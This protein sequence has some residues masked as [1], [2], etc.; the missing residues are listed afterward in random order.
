MRNP[1][2][3]VLC[4]LV[5]LAPCMLVGCD[6]P[7]KDRGGRCTDCNKRLGALPSGTLPAKEVDDAR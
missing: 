4:L 7:A 2:L 3:L 1:F 5:I 6:A